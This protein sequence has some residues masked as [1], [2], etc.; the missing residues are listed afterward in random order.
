MPGAVLEVRSKMC[1]V[2]FWIVD[3]LKPRYEAPHT[4][5]VVRRPSN[6]PPPQ[7]AA[8]S[9]IAS[10][11]RGNGAPRATQ[12]AGRVIA[13]SGFCLLRQ[14]CFGL[15]R[16]HCFSLR[17]PEN[18]VN[19]TCQIYFIAAVASPSSR[20]AMTSTP[21]RTSCMMATAVMPN[22]L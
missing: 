13:L 4:H 1:F 6:S 16:S 22:T 10:M 20:K 21:A 3:H 7:L 5:R 19:P 18:R 11:V 12:V 9:L 17:P 8:T 15:I 14:G 2:C